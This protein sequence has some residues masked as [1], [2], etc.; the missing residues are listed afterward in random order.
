MSEMGDTGEQV[1]TAAPGSS[2]RGLGAIA[3]VLGLVAALTVAAIALDSGTPAAAAGLEQFASCGDLQAFTDDLQGSV[4]MGEQ[5]LLDDA[6]RASDGLEAG[7]GDGGD[8]EQSAAVAAGA[9]AEEAPTAEAPT[10]VASSTGSDDSGGTNT[11]VE[12]VDEIDVIDRVAPDRLLV[13]RQGALA[14]VD[15]D[16]L[17]VVAELRGVPFDARVSAVDGIVF[18]AG[19]SVDGLG[20]EVRRIRIDGDS[21]VE[22]GTW[23]TTGY[24]VDA[25]SHR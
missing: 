1:L 20:T 8:T 2:S 12:G 3:G 18:V 24:L 16:G 21:F 15:L 25:A 5:I 4:P 9:P 14:L 6:A 17:T 7:A 13:S 22:E 11:V 19:G 23:S 10:T